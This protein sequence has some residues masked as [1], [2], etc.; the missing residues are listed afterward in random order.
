MTV[1]CHLPTIF[2][3][4]RALRTA[5]LLSLCVALTTTLLFATVSHAVSGVN[6]TLS[7]QGRLLQT[8]GAVVPDGYYNIQFKIY[9]DGDGAQQ[10]DT[11]GTGGALK[12]TESYVNN[13]SNS[14]VQV[15]NGFFS[16]NLGSLNAFGS[17]VDW[18]QDTLWLSMNVAGSANTCTTF[19]G[20]GCTA[21]GEMTPMKRITSTPYAL[22][23]GMLGGKTASNFVQLAQG[24]QTDASTNT[25]SIFINKTGSGNLLQLQNT[26]TDAFTLTNSGD[27]AFGVNADHSITVGTAGAGTAGNN[28][29]VSAG[30]GGSGT[31]AAGGSL[32][33]QGGAAGGTNGNGGGVTI[34]AGAATGSG[35]AGTVAIG[36]ANAGTINIG[37]QSGGTQ[38]INIGNNTSTGTTTVAGGTTSIQSKNDTTITTNGTQQAR[39][40]GSSN[41]LY[42]GNA[43]SSGQAVT[44]NSY[45]IQGTSSTGSNVQGGSLTLQAG[46][47]TSG[48]AN[49]GNLVLS[50]GSGVG[51]GASGLVV[52]STPTYSTIS[53][54]G[55]CYTS[56]ANVAANCTVAQSSVDSAS[57]ILVGFSASS[58][59]ATVPNPT[60]TTAGRVIYIIASSTSSDFTL[61]INGGSGASN[62]TAMRANT[63]ATLIWNGSA[64]TVAGA[65]N[66]TTLQ[67]AYNNTLQSS[68][69]AELVVSKTSSTNGLTIRDSLTNSVNGTLLQVQS[70]T[71]AN[72]FS[73]S[74]NV[75]DY[76]S[77]N[78]AE[79][80]GSTASTFPSSTWGS[81]GGANVTRNTTTTD[82]SIATGQASVSAIT[83][84][85]GDG[86]SNQIVDPTAGTAT[87]LNG[88]T[89]Y[90]VSF[91]TRLP[92]NATSS[93]NS[94]QILYQYDG[95]STDTVQCATAQQVMQTSWTK[96]DCTFTTPAASSITT[97]NMIKIVQT[98]STGRTFYVDNLSVTLAASQNYAADGGADSAAGTNW[99]GTGGASVAEVTNNGY[100][101]SNSIQATTTGSA[102]SG[103]QNNLAVNPIPS[104]NYRI[105]VEV[106]TQTYSLSSFKIQYNNGS[107]TTSCV[108][109]NTQTVLAS[110][111]GWTQIT[112]II[113]VPSGS[114]SS[115]YVTFLQNDTQARSDLFV[116]SFSMT[117][118]TA[119]TPDVQVGSG[120]NGGPVTLFTL[121][122][123]ASA[124]IESGNTA[125]FGSMYYDTSLGKIQCYQQSGWGSCGAAPDNIITI[126][127]EYNNAVMHGPSVGTAGV[128]TMTSDFCS[129]SLHINDGTNSQPTICGTNE[130]Y[131]FYK[132]T[133][134]Q[135]STSP[136]TY[137]IYVTYQLPSTFKSFASGQT[138][139][140]ARNDNG[141]S[142]GSASVS[143]K[144]YKSH[145]SSGLTPCGSA[146]SASSGTVTSW[147]PGVAIGTSD[148]STCGFVANDSIV[149]EIDM[150]A[151]ANA[152]AYVS[153]IGFTFSNQ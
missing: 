6:Q 1:W 66:S 11:G 75:S 94:L 55:N 52:L 109:Y 10:G 135:A 115:P 116:D 16:V 18:N 82:G 67:A 138:S 47:A 28:L 27:I 126:S 25:S 122:S 95:T 49:G 140:K 74:S 123:S 86:I 152:N 128:G 119:T 78:G 148:P 65:S 127:P 4:R 120:S 143:Y 113:Q 61:L 46:S 59:T 50:G 5:G 38:T 68:G 60:I 39:F 72:L 146:V 139:I 147:Q 151:D 100:T 134:P 54:D 20:T 43:N 104:N 88:N 34:D 121:D 84:A 105:S 111:T 7:Y 92:A 63:T 15:T 3:Q 51:S 102:T 40:S 137:A 26:G 80:A 87:K 62:Q 93:F 114:P 142:G 69:G 132:W 130:T 76:A 41:T 24:V 108:D 23:S 124:P 150:T 99:V 30:T 101:K 97:A 12:W 35:T 96:I 81:V 107:A 77:D 14:G 118:A 89:L 56:G 17:Q 131:N 36:T 91:S 117:L 31:G 57:A 153:N 42:V 19:N 133:S 21:D 90:S 106:Q 149:F 112:C 79:T 8:S 9:Q 13:N 44:A 110:A 129:N 103:I 37:S 32:T 45:T 70:K 64:W 141:S 73:V 83:S 136:Q 22:N 71:A 125:L 145:A 53:N 33:L 48:N 144:I 98:D 85:T 29:S 2:K 58:K